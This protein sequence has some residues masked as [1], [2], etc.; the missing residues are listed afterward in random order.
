MI[1][2]YSSMKYRSV[3]FVRFGQLPVDHRNT[4]MV[5]WFQW[6]LKV[7]CGPVYKVVKL[8]GPLVIWRTIEY[9]M[10]YENP[11][12]NYMYIV[13]RDI[14]KTWHFAWSHFCASKLQ[15]VSNGSRRP[16][17]VDTVVYIESV[18]GFVI[19]RPH[20]RFAK[21]GVICTALFE[22]EFT[23]GCFPFSDLA[24]ISNLATSRDPSETA[25]KPDLW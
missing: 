24:T 16:R 25:A 3:L 14:S 4:R 15:K 17:Q 12:P 11:V 23:G 21:L 8:Y 7:L 18:Q 22:R 20:S 13:V 6:E 9:R 19:W 10:L 5:I 2:T 1:Q